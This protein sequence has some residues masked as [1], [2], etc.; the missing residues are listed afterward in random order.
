MLFK[1]SKKLKEYAQLSGEINFLSLKATLRMVEQKHI[2]TILGKGLYSILDTD[3]NAEPDENALPAPI[4][5]LLLQ[6]RMVIGPMLCCYHIDKSDVILGDSGAQ[7]T[8]TAT[9]KT[10][11]QYQGTKFKEANL[12]EGEDATELLLQFL[13]DNKADYPLWTASDIFKQYRSLFIKTGNEFNELYPS[14]SPY[15]NYWAM[16]TKMLDVEENIIRPFLGDTMIDALKV[17]DQTPAPA[18]STKEKQLLFKLKK[19]IANYTVA[20]AVPQMNVRINANGLSVIATSSFSTNDNDNT[21]SLA[22]DTAINALIKSC[23]T[24]GQEWITNAIKYLKDNK[25]DFPDWIGFSET[26][27]IETA[28]PNADLKGTFGMA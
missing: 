16:R 3:Y 12:R 6:C 17:I 26:T 20:F 18:F 9:N 25:T 19:A 10:A 11:F 15:R 2:I 5:K 21:R 28:S 13:E 7:R 4:K 22:N 8:E 1:D 27:I 14:Q 24:T 23:N